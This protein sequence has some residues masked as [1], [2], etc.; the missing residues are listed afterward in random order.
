MK[1]LSEKLPLLLHSLGFSKKIQWSFYAT[2]ILA[3]SGLLINI[4]I[5]NKFGSAVLGKFNLTLALYVVFSQLSTGGIYYSTLHFSADPGLGMNEQKQ[6]LFNGLVTV[7]IWGLLTS[8]FVFYAR[9]LIQGIFTSTNILP[10]IISFIPALFF[11]SL[12]KV[13]LSFI[14]G[15]NNIKTYSIIQSIRYLLLVLFFFI[16]VYA[17][18]NPDYLISVFSLA[19]FIL[20]IFLLVTLKRLNYIDGIKFN[21]RWIQKHYSHGIKALISGLLQD[22]LTRTDILILGIMLTSYYVGVYSF[23]ALIAEGFFQIPMTF[24]I[25]VNPL[26]SKFISVNDKDSLKNLF[27]KTGRTIVV[28]MVI[29]FLLVIIFFPVLISF[30]TKDYDLLLGMKIMIILI[31]SM[32]I[33]APFYAFQLIFNQ[34]GKPIYYSILMIIYFSSN[35]ILNVILIKKFGVIGSALASASANIVYI[36]TFLIFVK[37]TLSKSLK[38]N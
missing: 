35:V 14:N 37:V 5:V 11:F 1:I 7:T 25:V 8:I 2:S 16:Y 38:V 6:M 29:L 18:L 9:F 17:N 30:F 33:C 19:E 34:M 27:L 22:V 26:I 15:I 21:M 20:L 10:G 23:P 4:V 12:N 31:T 28:L 24:L 32:I 13:M 36:I 3:I